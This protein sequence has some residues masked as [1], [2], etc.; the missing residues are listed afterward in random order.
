MI[1]LMTCLEIYKIFV[2]IKNKYCDCWDL[3]RFVNLLCC[4]HMFTC[5]HDFIIHKKKIF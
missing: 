3:I 1:T 2:K 5:L 4:L